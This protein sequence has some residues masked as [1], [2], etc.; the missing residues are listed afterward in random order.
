MKHY[1]TILIRY[2]FP[3]FVIGSLFLI[4]PSRMTEAAP[5]VP[6]LIEEFNGTSLNLNKWIKVHGN[7]TV[8]NGKLT[9]AGGVNTTAEIQSLKKFAYGVLQMMITSSNWRPQEGPDHV[10]DSSFGFEIRQ[11][12]NGQCQYSV[13]LIANGNL[14]VI[15]QKPDSNGNCSGDPLPTEQVYKKITNWDTIRAGKTLRL[16]LTWAPKSVTLHITS[17]NINDGVAY[18]FVP[19]DPINSLEIRLNADK[20][21]T[22]KIDYVRVVGIP[23]R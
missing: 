4:T 5:T 3:A 8:A 11:G 14:G 12:T 9:L 18:Y 23:W 10:T 15:R 2:I 6:T 1:H 17:G 16:T 19:V 22:Y 21:E 13:I 7:P 20:S